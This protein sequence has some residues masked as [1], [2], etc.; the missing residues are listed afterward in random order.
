MNKTFSFLERYFLHSFLSVSCALLV[1]A[2]Q[3]LPIQLHVKAKLQ[4]SFSF[5]IAIFKIHGVYFICGTLQKAKL[6]PLWRIYL[7]SRNWSI[8][9]CV[10]LASGLSPQLRITERWIQDTEFTISDTSTINKDE[11]SDKSTQVF[12]DIYFVCNLCSF[13][14]VWRIIFVL[15]FQI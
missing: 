6:S 7:F 11:I 4:V 2:G 8:Y 1:L 15:N 3:T 5:K 9:P 13:L 12:L 10:L 14:G